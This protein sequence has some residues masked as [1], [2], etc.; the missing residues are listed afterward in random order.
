M[1]ENDYIE[2]YYY[3]L[4]MYRKGENPTFGKYPN[5]YGFRLFVFDTEEKAIQR[6]SEQ[7]E[8]MYNLGREA[9]RSL[10]MFIMSILIGGYKYEECRN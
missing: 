9:V 7:D 3:D 5:N 10:D 4:Q 2:G 1:T 6:Q 8:Y